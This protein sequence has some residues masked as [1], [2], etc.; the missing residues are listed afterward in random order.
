MARDKSPA[1]SKTKPTLSSVLGQ[2]PPTGWRG[3]E[4]LV[5]TLLRE[6]T[7][8]PLILASAGLQG[9]L[10]AASHRRHGIQIAVEC[11]RYSQSRSLD[12]RELRAEVDSA[13]NENPDLDLWVLVAS[14]EIATQED[15]ALSAVSDE[16]GVAYLSL[17]NALS[18][19]VGR[20]DALCSQYEASAVRYLEDIG[21]SALLP[22]FRSAVSDIR[23]RAQYESAC[24][25]LMDAL[26]PAEIGFGSFATRLNN[27][28]LADTV[29]RV[30]CKR[31]F[32][33]ALTPEALHKPVAR[34]RRDQILQEI[35]AAWTAAS[36]QQDAC[37]LLVLGDEG[38]GKS[39]VVTQWLTDVA[40]TADPPAIFYIPASEPKFNGAME[41]LVDH[42]RHYAMAGSSKSSVELKLRRWLGGGGTVTGRRAIVV[43][44]GINERPDTSLWADLVE[45]FCRLTSAFL[46]VTCRTITWEDRFRTAVAAKL[47]TVKV[48]DFTEAEFAYRIATLPR[49]QQ[50]AIRSAGTLVRRPRY[51]HLALQRVEELRQ[52]EALTAELLYYWD[53]QHRESL[54]RDMSIDGTDFSDVIRQLARDQRAGREL[55]R[56]ALE[57]ALGAERFK[58]RQEEL[59]SSN[60]I[61]RTAV[62]WRMHK[63]YFALGLGMYLAARIDQ[64]GG[65]INERFAV[66]DELFGDTAALDLTTSVLQH[67]LLHTLV[68]GHAYDRRTQLALLSV[69][70]NALNSADTLIAS[71]PQL[72]FAPE[73][74]LAFAEHHWQENL[75]SHVMEQAVLAALVRLMRETAHRELCER[76]LVH[77]AGL[78]HEH[79]ES[80]DRSDV[81]TRRVQADVDRLC[82]PLEHELPVSKVVIRR[83]PTQSLVKLGRLA[84][85]AVSATDV[86]CYWPVVATAFV[87]DQVMGGPRTELLAWLIRWCHEPLDD[88]IDG[89]S[90]ALMADAD[91][92]SLRAAQRLIHV[93]GSQALLPR[94][95]QLPPESFP[96]S[97]WAALDSGKDPCLTFFRTPTSAELPGCLDR[98]DVPLHINVT[99]ARGFASDLAFAFPTTFAS[100]IESALDGIDASKLRLQMGRAQVDHELDSLQ[101]LGLR[102]A[103]GAF[104]AV[105]RRLAHD[106]VSRSGMPLRQAALC[107]EEFQDL[108]DESAVDAVR[109]TLARVNDPGVLRPEDVGFLE[110]MLVRTVLSHTGASD[111]LGVLLLRGQ[112]AP[113]IDRIRAQFKQL[114]PE[115]QRSLKEWSSDALRVRL[116]LWFMSA[117]RELDADTVV[118]LVR[119]GLTSGD[120]GDRGLALQMMLRLE[121]KN[122]GALLAQHRVVRG[123][124]ATPYERYFRTVATVL[125]EAPGPDAL[126]Y[127]SAEFLGDAL[128]RVPRGAA[129]MWAPT[130]AD[131]LFRSAYEQLARGASVSAFLEVDAGRTL[132]P[133]R[134]ISAPSY[135]SQNTS[136][137]SPMSIWGGLPKGDMGSVF[138]AME[139]KEGNS[140]DALE[141]ALSQASAIGDWFYGAYIPAK[142]IGLLAEHIP[143]TI[144]RLSELFRHAADHGRIHRL[145]AL[146]EA[147]IEWGLLEGHERAFDWYDMLETTQSHT[148]YADTGTE[149]LRRH[150]ALTRSA[151]CPAAQERWRK[152]ISAQSNDLDLYRVLSSLSICNGA[153]LLEEAARELA[154]GSPRGRA[155]ALLLVSAVEDCDHA[156]TAVQAQVCGDRQCWY[157][158]LAEMAWKYVHRGRDQRQWL[159]EALLSDDP[160]A[161][162]RAAALLE[163]TGHPKLRYEI[164][165]A[166]DSHECEAVE[167]SRVAQLPTQN[168]YTRERSEW[169]KNMSKRLLGSRIIDH[170]LAPWLPSGVG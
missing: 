40:A 22:G 26:Q 17:G 170:S 78:V 30:T 57:S 88:L 131:L 164:E 87:A 145:Q 103:P 109:S 58:E 83:A 144:E 27:R 92:V 157:D 4:G 51:F 31:R 8:Q 154:T 53:W 124:Q 29:D 33:C 47:R 90:A 38:T 159:K 54:K 79:G 35:D 142:S 169:A 60:V 15:K 72:P 65:T 41:V 11:K 69:W 66:A 10:D 59:A 121:E 36:T 3:F 139:E 45:E 70:S 102:L 99:R 43:L 165:R 136:F 89:T 16:R 97:P 94:L 14:R 1:P 168:G 62:G 50:N 80:E 151:P 67:A 81:E 166:L 122:N 160:I 116:A 118:H 153:W 74:L 155:M 5:V 123:K 100:R 143:G 23:A 84:L 119:A 98:A 18:I 82:T 9:G 167:R 61:E 108:L 71:L 117:Q 147:A 127:V 101:P 68:S 135:R 46:V 148:R 126:Q 34:V 21:H 55:D 44:D 75:T 32:R 112:R 91:P 156:L 95:S 2:L 19:N 64:Q 85:A 86:R 42:A 128:L 111:Q 39:W 137:R 130:F 6:A 133:W 106:T 163:Y 93:L 49:E 152:L 158:Q 107:I 110:S 115:R 52:G 149:L 134:R 7:G 132:T 76:R 20:L 25:A 96:V 141:E 56:G 105:I 161:R 140:R 28:L 104:A 162:T 48:G 129:L 125:H 63:E 146:M 13:C 12:A 24:K 150:A 114:K 113:L 37:A 138:A 77:W 120:S 73:L